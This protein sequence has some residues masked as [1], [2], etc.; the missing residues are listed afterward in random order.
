MN[1]RFLA[2]KYAIYAFFSGKIEKFWN[3]TGVK[4]LTNS[5]SGGNGEPSLPREQRNIATL[6]V[7]ATFM[8]V[9]M[10]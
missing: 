10:K 1:S 9:M 7:R 6:I 3:L 5:M 2:K 4:D 8:K